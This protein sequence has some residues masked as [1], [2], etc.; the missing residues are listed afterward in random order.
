MFQI[1]KHL[2][3]ITSQSHVYFR[4]Q[5]KQWC[6]EDKVMGWMWGNLG[7]HCAQDSL[8]TGVTSRYV[9]KS[10]GQTNIGKVL[11]ELFRTLSTVFPLYKAMAV[12]CFQN[13]Q[14][15]H[16]EFGPIFFWISACP[17]QSSCSNCFLNK[18]NHLEVW[19]FSPEILLC[20]EKEK[21]TWQAVS[22]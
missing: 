17:P 22:W 14:P 5:R 2:G 9:G 7:S 10:K 11:G 13:S 4:L 1:S 19:L 18:E 20:K 8:A 15:G 12:Q 6:G 3:I 21:G 16:L